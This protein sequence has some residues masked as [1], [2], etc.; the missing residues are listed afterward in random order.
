[1]NY[2]RKTIVKLCTDNGYVTTP[3]D[4]LNSSINFYQKL[5]MTKGATNAYTLTKSQVLN[6]LKK[7][8]SIVKN[9]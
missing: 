7:T 9:Q 3:N 5:F 8:K 4:I 2:N 1:M 6:Y